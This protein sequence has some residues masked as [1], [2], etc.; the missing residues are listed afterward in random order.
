L[1]ALTKK[2]GRGGCGKDTEVP[3]VNALQK[4]GVNPAGKE[5]PKVFDEAHNQKGKGGYLNKRKI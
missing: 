3:G 1:A 5:E 2:R 4:E